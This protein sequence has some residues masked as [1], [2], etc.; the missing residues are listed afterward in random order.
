MLR[1]RVGERVRVLD[2]IGAAQS[3]T[4]VRVERNAVELC[5]DAWLADAAARESPLELRLAFAVLK[6]QKLELVLQKAT[7][8]GVRSFQP[9]ETLRNRE[10]KR[11]TDQYERWQRIVLEAVR[12]CDR[13]RLPTIAPLVGVGALRLLPDEVGLLFTTETRPESDLRSLLLG[14]RSPPPRACLVFG[15]EGGLEAAETEALQA[16]GFQPV[17]LGPRVLRAET[18]V[19]AALAV[20]QCVWGDLA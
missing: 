5:A 3:A 9:L 13:R 14:H 15:P 10:R 4:V 11:A 8:L 20:V 2:G 16:A 19:L 1:V 7:E 17:R 18:A 6:S 12:Q